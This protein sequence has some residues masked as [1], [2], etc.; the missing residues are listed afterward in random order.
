MMNKLSSAITGLNALLAVISGGIF[1]LISCLI[2]YDVIIRTLGFRTSGYTDVLISI[3]MII[4]A[5]CT[6]GYALHAGAHV[7]VELLASLMGSTVKRLMAAFSLLALLLL[8]LVLTKEGWTLA[9]DSW[10]MGAFMAQTVFPVKLAIPQFISA[11]G[12]S[13]FSLQIIITL[14]DL[15][16][17]SKNINS[18]SSE[19]A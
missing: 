18:S 3:S 6:L 17:T 16:L 19:V 1:L 13:M 14:L 15:G 7:K 10:E 5:T 11:I 12:Y 2:T 9:L 8:S 4:G